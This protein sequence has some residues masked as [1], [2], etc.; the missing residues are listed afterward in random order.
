[1]VWSSSGHAAVHGVGRVQ[2]DR[3]GGPRCPGG[4]A[5]SN[6]AGRLGGFGLG[7]GQGVT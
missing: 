5:P 4:D 3:F 2:P 7:L 6:P 1:M